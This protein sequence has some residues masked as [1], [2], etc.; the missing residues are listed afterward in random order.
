MPLQLVDGVKDGKATITIPLQ[1]G[2][3]KLDGHGVDVK[4]GTVARVQVD[5]KD[6]KCTSGGSLAGSVLTM[7]R[8][9]RHVTKFSGW[10]LQNAV[11]AATLN[12]ARAAGFSGTRGVLASGADADFTVLTSAGEV[13]KTVVGGR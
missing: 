7:D 2:R 10:S 1:P 3:Y 13:V 11:R 5:V 12:A 4:P 6:G 8:A 9:V